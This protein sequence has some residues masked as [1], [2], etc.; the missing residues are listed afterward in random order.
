[1][2]DD[3]F[4]IEFEN[5]FVDRRRCLTGTMTPE[6]LPEPWLRGTHAELPATTRAVVH[7]LE[8]AGEDLHHWC[9][10]LQ[11]QELV[12]SPDGLPPVSFQLRHIAR[13]LDR[14]LTYAEGRTLSESQL[15]A[16]KTESDLQATG[17]D[18][19]A[20]LDHA[21]ALS[22]DRVCAFHPSQFD[23]PCPVGRQALESTVGGLLIH[24][25]DHTQRHVGQAVTTA[26]VLLARREQKK[27]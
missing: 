22:I 26:K 24:V 9:E 21:L 5:G 7:A 23:H 11:D 12:T 1:L 3:V 6:N 13:S 2:R 17:A 16:L 20:E 19:F 18:L 8:L 15:S 10:G 27:P 25:A 14:L 4:I